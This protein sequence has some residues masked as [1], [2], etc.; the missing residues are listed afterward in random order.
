MEREA[1]TSSRMPLAPVTALI[2]ERSCF[3]RFKTNAHA[4]TA[5]LVAIKRLEKYVERASINRLKVKF[6]GAVTIQGNEKSRRWVLFG[7]GFAEAKGSRSLY[8]HRESH[9]SFR[10]L[11]RPSCDI[12]KWLNLTFPH[13]N[14]DS[15]SPLQG[16]AGSKWEGLAGLS[17]VARTP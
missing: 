1:V 15:E 12:N 14:G 3:S 11:L 10:R 16:C 5:G 4:H 17:S 13:Q 9:E 8:R 6:E 7:E 2:R